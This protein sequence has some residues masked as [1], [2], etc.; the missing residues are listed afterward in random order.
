MIKFVEERKR[1][2]NRHKKKKEIS[3]KYYELKN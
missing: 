3:N 1:R 2:G